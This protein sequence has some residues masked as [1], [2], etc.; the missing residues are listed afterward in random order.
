MNI[1]RWS[2]GMFLVG[3]IVVG[4]VFLSGKYRSVSDIKIPS[5]PKQSCLEKN[6]EKH[7]K[8]TTEE[9]AQYK[10]AYFAGGCFWCT[11]SDLQ[12]APGV[13]EVVSGYAGGHIENPT[14]GDVTSEQ[15]GHREAVE[16]YY[17]DTVT[18]F[19]R[20]V[21]YHLMH[22]D[23]T[24][25]GGQFYDR[26]ESYQAVIFYTTDEERSIVEKSLREL[27]DARVFEKTIAVRVLPYKNFYTAEEYHQNYAEEN[28]VKYCAYR[29]SSGR[30]AFLQKYFG[31]KTWEQL[32][33]SSVSSAV[34]S[35]VDKKDFSHFVK[36]SD[37]ELRA[38]LTDIQYD[39]T[40]KNGTEKPFQNEYNENHEA[41]IYVDIVSGE[42]LYS[43]RD[44]YDSG[45]GWPSFV[46]PIDP[47]SIV[48]K[49]D[50]GLFSTRTEIRSKYGDDH[51]GHVFNDGP[52]D[53]GGKRYCMNSAALRFIPLADMEKEGYGAYISSVE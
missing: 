5:I 46:R 18:N 28:T 15:S 25:A 26:G 3:A 42:A 20:L 53:R 17:D 30:D 27:G 4:G 37:A 14:Y 10:K 7:M 6:N 36:P 2:I 21:Q 52:A 38:K 39:V 51:L 22:I 41:G 19:E 24:D 31:G 40:Q 8:K 16:V 47:D 23:P 49:V 35:S 9:L 12:K 11:E 33:M 13:I 43:S 29:E 1:S 45:T 34:Q 50:N 32:T 44:K 48:E